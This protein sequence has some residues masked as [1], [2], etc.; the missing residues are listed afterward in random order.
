MEKKSTTAFVIGAKPPQTLSPLARRQ[1]SK[2]RPSM[3][4]HKLAENAARVLGAKNGFFVDKAAT[5]SA[6]TSKKSTSVK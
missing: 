1:L 2:A 6:R 4:A 5:T 3:K